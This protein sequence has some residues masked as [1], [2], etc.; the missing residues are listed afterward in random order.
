VDPPAFSTDALMRIGI[1][2]SMI[3]KII[4]THVHADHDS[5]VFQ[6][7]LS[8]TA[9]EIITT[10]TIMESFVRKHSAIIGISPEELR[11]LFQFR[12]VTMNHPLTL[13]GAIFQFFYSFHSI[14]CLG[15]KIFHG[16]ESIY[17][18]GDT[19]YD[20]DKLKEL[21]SK[22]ILTKS[23]YEELANRNLENY[24]YI[25]HE[26]GG[27]PIH[28]T[29]DVLRAYPEEVKEKMIVYH[30]PTKQIPEDS[31]LTKACC[32]LSN[33]LVSQTNPQVII[34]D[35]FKDSFLRNLEIVS[36]IDFFEKIPL[37]RICDLIRSVKEVK[38]KQS[39]FIVREGTKG[40]K[41]YVVKKG[42]CKIYSR[43][44]GREFSKFIYPG[45]L[46][47][48]SAITSNGIRLAN[49][50]SETDCILLEINKHDFF[51]CLGSQL[52]TGA[53]SLIRNL[54]E[55]RHTKYGEFINK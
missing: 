53:T 16:D 7:I 30:I 10:K 20:P 19:F 54:S 2:P 14:P 22:G 9:T 43:K 40:N 33:T 18:T 24:T 8:A 25:L 26:A 49:V 36:S 31:G 47:G 55:L 6:K 39:D 15:F 37:K 35:L 46:F 50:V 13:Y 1:P 12:P 45:D 28:T 29:V 4:L 44:T 21:H 42:V 34:K 32:G 17:Y 11:K 23:R 3:D 27:L 5:G 41:F 52:E 51:W 48:E 38:Y